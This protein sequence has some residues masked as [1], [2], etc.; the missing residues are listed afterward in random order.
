MI[1]RIYI[2]TIRRADIQITFDNL[3]KELQNRVV[4]VIEPEERPLY[5]YDC[6]YLEIPKEII[7]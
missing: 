3:P 1:E 5:K 7:S 6:E 4:M 2:P